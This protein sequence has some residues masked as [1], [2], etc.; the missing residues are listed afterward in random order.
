MSKVA[1]ANYLHYMGKQRGF[2]AVNL[3]LYSVY[4]PLEDTS[5][6]LPT[7]LREAS[8]GETSAVSRSTDITGTSYTST[9]YAKPSF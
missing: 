8:A 5:R 1:I 6:L 4:G 2:P 3:R 7:L 9:T